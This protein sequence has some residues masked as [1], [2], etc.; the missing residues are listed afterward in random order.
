MAPRISGITR[1]FKTPYL[2]Q[3]TYIPVCT[4]NMHYRR[5]HYSR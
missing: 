5:M 2:K 4:I 3:Y 1:A